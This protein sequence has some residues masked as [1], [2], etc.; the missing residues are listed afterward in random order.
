[1]TCIHIQRVKDLLAENSVVVRGIDNVININTYYEYSNFDIAPIGRGTNCR[2]IDCLLKKEILNILNECNCIETKEWEINELIRTGERILQITQ[3]QL[4]T[5]RNDLTQKQTC[6]DELTRQLTALQI[7]NNRNKDKIR[8]LKGELGQSRENFLN[9][10][11]SSK[12]EKLETLTQQL[13]VNQV[14]IT[15]LRNAYQQLINACSNSNQNNINAASVNVRNVKAALEVNP[16][17]KQKICRKCEKLVKLEIE[18]NQVYQQQF[19]AR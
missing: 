14:Q 1:M 8:D 12:E 15:N 13:G 6:I 18:L 19:E 10:K 17:N 11:M 7:E 9:Q 5:T 3:N 2:S 4:T 16:A